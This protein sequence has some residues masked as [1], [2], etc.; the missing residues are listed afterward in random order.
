MKPTS[1]QWYIVRSVFIFISLVSMC[2]YASGVTA[3]RRLCRHGHAVLIENVYFVVFGFCVYCFWCVCL[4]LSTATATTRFCLYSIR[5][6]HVPSHNTQIRCEVKRFFYVEY[7]LHLLCHFVLFSA[8]HMAEQLLCNWTF[9]KNRCWSVWLRRK[10]E[11][12]AH[13]ST[14]PRIAL[15]H[16]ANNSTNRYPVKP[17]WRQKTHSLTLTPFRSSA[18]NLYER[19]M[20]MRRKKNAHTNI[21]NNRKHVFSLD[22]CSICGFDARRPL[23]ASPC[24]SNTGATHLLW[25]ASGARRIITCSMFSARCLSNSFVWTS[26]VLAYALLSRR[27]PMFCNAISRVHSLVTNEPYD[28]VT[29]DSD[30]MPLFVGLHFSDWL[31]PTRQHKPAHAITM[32]V[33]ACLALSHNFCCYWYGL[34]R[35]EIG[36]VQSRCSQCSCEFIW[37][38]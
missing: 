5:L 30:T 19:V 10:H 12:R 2:A 29:V 37:H 27:M 16:G 15:K 20:K 1:P 23:P 8:Q 17:K 25:C 28:C 4:S 34:I 38:F 3:T 21:N 11:I 6:K 32:H 18:K 31:V 9:N 26:F 13:Q 14:S 24:R 33:R 7:A 22:A 36:R 35:L